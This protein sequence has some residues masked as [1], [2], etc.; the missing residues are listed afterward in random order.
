MLAEKIAKERMRSESLKKMR[1]D[2]IRKEKIGIVKLPMKRYER[3][4]CED[5]LEVKKTGVKVEW[6]NNKAYT[7]TMISQIFQEFGG[8]TKMVIEGFTAKILFINDMATVLLK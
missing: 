4:K 1:G 5:N 2:L 3:P 7:N 8:I 6:D